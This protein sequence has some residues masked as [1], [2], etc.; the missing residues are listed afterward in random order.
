[1]TKFEYKRCFRVFKN[2]TIYYYKNKLNQ[3]PN[4]YVRKSVDNNLA[5]ISKKHPDMVLSTLRIWLT[6]NNYDKWTM[7]I[8]RKACRHL[9]KTH[10]TEVNELL[11]GESMIN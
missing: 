6:E 4:L 1:M 3:D 9:V 8:A 5:D 7:F 11:K 10:Q 2:L